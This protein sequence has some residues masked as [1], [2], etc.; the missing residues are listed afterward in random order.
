MEQRRLELVFAG[1]ICRRGDRKHASVLAA[2][3]AG[4]WANAWGKAS[5]REDSLGSVWWARLWCILTTKRAPNLSQ[6]RS[7]ER[8]ASDVAKQGSKRQKETC[9]KTSKEAGQETAVRSWGPEHVMGQINGE[10]RDGKME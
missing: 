7:A 3:E 8:K 9:G 1:K 10:A 6:F 5:C 4:V 2:A